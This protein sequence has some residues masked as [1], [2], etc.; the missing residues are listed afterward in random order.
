MK[1]TRVE[2]KVTITVSQTLVSSSH[3]VATPE[4]QAQS[5]AGGRLK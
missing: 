1:N 4:N 2:P 5:G 3:R